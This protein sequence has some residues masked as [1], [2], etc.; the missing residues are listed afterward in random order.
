MRIAALVLLAALGSTTWLSTPPAGTL[1][2][3]L[4]RAGTYIGR[5]DE[6]VASVVAEEHYQQR[7]VIPD[8]LPAGRATR[9]YEEKRNIRSD[10]L[11]V[12]SRQSDLWIPFRDVFEVDGRP[13]R[14]REER[15]T[16][17]LA[18][19]SG[20]SYDRAR[21][22]TE[23]GARYNIGPVRRTV[24]I[25]TQ[26]LQFLRASNQPRSVFR[27]TG[28]ERVDGSAAWEIQFEEVGLPT[29]IRTTGGAS[30]PAAGSFWIEP[31][32]G[33]VLR[34]LIRTRLDDMRAEIEVGFAPSD[35]V[36]VRLPSELREKYRGRNY[37]LD[38]VATYTRFRRFRITTDEAV[39]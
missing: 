9:P 34:S 23:E 36:D 17:L 31:A 18:D 28:E 29:L 26:A 22:L 39:R 6:A 19:A 38:G 25:P 21:R 12:R 27:K 13:V 15:L 2:E 1:P 5:F 3:V 14:E 35:V 33:V 24:N 7:Y 32:S 16:R 8:A 4:G 10:F 37:Q 20:S 30:L 11:M